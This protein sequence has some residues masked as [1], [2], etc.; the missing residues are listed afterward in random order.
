MIF[1]A[2]Y[3]AKAFGLAFGGNIY[4]TTRSKEN[5]KALEAA[6]IKPL[7]FPA[8]AFDG[9]FYNALGAATHLI[10]SIAP[11]EAG[12]CVLA[13]REI[14]SN[15]PALEW[16]CYLST[17]GVYGNHHGAWIDE[18]ATCHPTLARNKKRLEVEKQWQ[19]FA[20]SRKIPLAVLRLGGI[21]GRSRNVF[22][23]LRDKTARQI[24]KDG[25]VFNR[26]HVE[27][28]AGI[29]NAFARKKTAG[30]YNI[31]DNEPSPPQDVITYAAKLMGKEPPAKIPF[32]NAEMSPMARSFYGDNKRILNEK[33]LKTGYHLKYPTY[34]VAL[35]DMWMRN[36]WS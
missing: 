35:D 26:I 20:D 31:V 32:D 27:D 8:P 13:N 3:S 15:M 25:Q 29:I 19:D 34:R 33:L 4:G 12:D 23:K 36:V 30:L 10:L 17:I 7:L 21:Y 14:L 22:V 24:I 6:H 5:F 1:G 16:I 18:K 9:E 28:I 2:G 11:G